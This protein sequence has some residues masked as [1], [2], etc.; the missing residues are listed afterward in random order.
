MKTITATELKSILDQHQ[1]WIE[2]KGKQGQDANLE[3]ANLWRANLQGANLRGANLGGAN[4]GGANL[5]GANLTGANLICANLRGANLRGANLTGAKLR[6]ANLTDANLSRTDLKGANL[7]GANLKDADLRDADLTNTILDKK[8]E[9]GTTMIL[10]EEETAA[11]LKM[12][13]DKVNKAKIDARDIVIEVI[14][15]VTNELSRCRP[16][17]ADIMRTDD[18]DEV[19]G[20]ENLETISLILDLMG[21]KFQALTANRRAINFS[22]KKLNSL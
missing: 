11:I 20:S 1:L 15:L 7:T 16:S 18:C 14:T 9:Q 4:L 12:R 19:I 13:A 6:G 2:T 10:S 5:Q 3:G 8:K 21:V 22:Y 17:N